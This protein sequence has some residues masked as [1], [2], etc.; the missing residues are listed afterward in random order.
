[1][2]WMS[3]GEQIESEILSH[4]PLIHVPEESGMPIY[5]G[6]Y[7]MIDILR[8]LYISPI[9]RA[10]S[11]LSSPTNYPC[12][13]ILLLRVLWITVNAKPLF[14]RRRFPNQ[15]PERWGFRAPETQSTNRAIRSNSVPTENTILSEGHSVLPWSYD[16]GLKNGITDSSPKI[17]RKFL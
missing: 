1:M 5:V 13:A 4:K 7:H 17:R 16:H 10:L 14:R 12:K 6:G 9:F 2:C 8:L 15:Y 3:L 11:G